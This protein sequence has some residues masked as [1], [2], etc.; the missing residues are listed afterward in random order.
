[1]K[2]RTVET[3]ETLETTKCARSHRYDVF[4]PHASEDKCFARPLSQKLQALGLRVWFDETAMNPGDSL[5]EEID[6]GLATSDFGVVILSHNF[7]KKEWTNSE[8][9]GLFALKMEGRN[10]IIPVWHDMTKAELVDYSPMVA[11]TTSMP[12]SL[13]C[14]GGLVSLCSRW[15]ESDGRH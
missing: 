8:L 3:R 13:L 4:I 12:F 5:R 10:R 14:F 7:F 1:M 9:K 2:S 11:A 15:V 6:H